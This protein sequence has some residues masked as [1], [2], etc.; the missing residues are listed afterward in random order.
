[1]QDLSCEKCLST[2]AHAERKKTPRIFWG[3]KDFLY[4]SA[5]VLTN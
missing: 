2:F 4:S 3:D 5:A 1:M